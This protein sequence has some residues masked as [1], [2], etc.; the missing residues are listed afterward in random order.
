M[1]YR[2]LLAT[3]MLPAL[4]LSC[5]SAAITINPSNPIQI[6]LSAGD[7]KITGLQFEIT[8]KADASITSGPAAAGK[9]MM[10]SDTGKTRKAIIFSLSREILASGAV[11]EIATDD[12]Q[13]VT[14]SNALATDEF[15]HAIPVTVPEAK[16]AKSHKKPKL[17]C[18]PPALDADGTF[19]VG[20]LQAANLPDAK[21]CV[22]PDG[23]VAKPDAAT[24][25]EKV[26][27]APAIE[28][29]K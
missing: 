4:A 7:C 9:T 6:V 23:T 3:A 19:T 17:G 1:L 10:L 5:D 16:P 28:V 20:D 18:A 25:L 29:K 26:L 8:T 12:G 21:P 27:T 14:V 11:I 2:K 22:N 24:V 13:P 15:G